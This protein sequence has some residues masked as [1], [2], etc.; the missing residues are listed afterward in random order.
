MAD[1]EQYDFRR[2]HP[3]IR[4]GTASDRYAGWVGQIYPEGAYA[5]S[6]R[7]RR[8]GGVTYQE[9]QVP[10]ASVA[11]Y[12]EHFECLE[13]DFTFY[14]PLLEADGSAGSNYFVLR[15]YAEAAPPHA[16]FFVKAPQLYAAR[17]IWSSGGFD[18]NERYLDVEGYRERFLVPCRE[19][20][21]DRLGGIIFEQEYQRKRESP[22]EE[23]H[24]ALLDAFFSGLDSDPQTHLEIRSEH[25]I[26][27]RYIDWLRDRGLGFV[28]SHWTWLPSLKEQ[29]HRLEGFPARD[30]QAVVRLLTPR[31]IPYEKAYALGHPFDRPVPELAE[32]GS[33][34]AMI[35]ETT[36]LIFKAIELGSV[37]NILV[38]NRAYGNAPE[39]G[40]EI[41]GRFLDVARRRELG[42]A[43]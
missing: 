39:L 23:E 37:L 28:F 5:I 16:R 7:S 40:R 31:R 29:W 15:N 21:G 26:T 17:R 24:I 10:I 35:D 41:A 30:G 4:F 20:L 32:D 6:S 18:A 34:R 9:R 43:D 27:P 22:P 19:I 36:A 13:L 11:D 2:L 3:A 8:L 38:N 25:L 1:L 14:R 12:F 33:I 42:G